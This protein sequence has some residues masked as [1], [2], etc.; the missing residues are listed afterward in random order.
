M[1]DPLV[2]LAIVLGVFAAA[3]LAAAVQRRGAGWRRTRR[4][5]EGVDPGLV[6]FSS[7]TCGS[8]DRAAEVLAGLE[9]PHRVIR[10]ETQPQVFDRLDIRRV[11]SVAWIGSGGNGW[12]SSGVPRAFRLRRWLAD[13]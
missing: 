10:Y 6:L 7:D 8:C 4:R 12:I 5:F 2:R 13:P 3:G 11:P 1:S 9:Q